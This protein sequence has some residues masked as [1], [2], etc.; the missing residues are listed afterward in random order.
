MIYSSRVKETSRLEEKIKC[1]YS[2][3]TYYKTTL[4]AN[5]TVI[6][7]FTSLKLFKPCL[8]KILLVSL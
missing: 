7:D 1:L 5:F 8:Y 4:G 6:V 3:D 2:Q